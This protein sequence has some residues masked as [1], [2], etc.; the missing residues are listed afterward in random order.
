RRAL[1][2][3]FVSGTGGALRILPRRKTGRAA[4]TVGSIRRFRVVGA[5]LAWRRAVATA[6]GLLEKA[7]EWRPADAGIAHRSA[8]SRGAEFARRNRDSAAFAGA[9]PGAQKSGDS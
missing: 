4:R 3:H 2:R 1:V 6:V 8:A 5:G 7:V 9:D